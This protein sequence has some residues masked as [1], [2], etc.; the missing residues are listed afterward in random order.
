MEKM[1]VTMPQ[2]EFVM[3]L[4]DSLKPL[5]PTYIEDMMS[6]MRLSNVG[7]VT[8]KIVKS[9]AKIESAG[10]DVLDD[11]TLKPR[12]EGLSRFFSGYMHRADLDQTVGG[13]SPDCVL[14]RTS[15]VKQWF[16]KIELKDG[17]DIYYMPKAVFKRVPK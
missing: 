4:A 6:C 14:V 7:A 10:Y 13:F 2:Q 9:G 1:N 12:F 3:I 16:P 15:A 8:G 11:K 5:D 17:F